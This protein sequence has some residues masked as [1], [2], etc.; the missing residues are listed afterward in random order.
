MPGS[1]EYSKPNVLV[2]VLSG[3][4]LV[5]T[6]WAEGWRTLRFPERSNRTFMYGMPFDHARS[7]GCRRMLD[8]D[9]EW[10]FF[11]DDDVIP[12]P[13]TINRLLAYNADIV[14]GLY[15]RR[16]MPPAPVMMRDVE[17]EGGQWITDY[18]PGSLVEADLIG[19]GCMLVKRK[20][21]EIMPPPWFE[22]KCDPY[23]WP[24]LKPYERCSEDYDFC[25]KARALGF[26]LYVD[27]SI[28]CHHAGL[29][30]ASAQGFTPL[31]LP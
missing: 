17:G 27:T 7:Q 11:L 23:R 13:D 21:L 18:P 14:G 12:P 31:Q 30:V 24:D 6:A 25:R 1:W 15:Y 16:Q 3:R 20:V 4:E 26:K 22:W 2:V 28:Q 29:S 8:T 10:M 5:T 9:H 19:S